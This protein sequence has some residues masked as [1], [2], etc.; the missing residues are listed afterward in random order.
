VRIGIGLNTSGSVDDLVERAKALAARDVSS[1]WVSQIFGWD[2][3]T[4]LAVVGREVPDVLLGTAVVPVHPRHPAILAAQ[5]KTVQSAIG[6]RLILGIGLS[7]QVVVEGVWGLKYERP[8]KHMS[9]YLSILV[10]MLQGESVAFEGELVTTRSIG[11]LETPGEAPRVLVAALGPA[12]LR[13]AGRQADGTV[14]WMVGLRTLE[15]HIVPSINAAASEAGRPS[16]MVVVHLPVCV[17]SDRQ[18]ALERAGKTFAMYG[19]LPS[20]K[21]MLDRE[22]AAGPPDVAVAGTETEVLDAL[23]RVSEAGATDFSGVAF[24]T[25]EEIARTQDVLGEAA[26]A[27]KTG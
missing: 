21:A 9:E 17:T 4:A 11:P 16:P 22:G 20:Y 23:K 14:T 6:G 7:H 24:G 10:P 15:D 8:A 12:M 5:A 27:A 18:A 26:R 13:V 25:R 1:L 2:A 19:R 3:L